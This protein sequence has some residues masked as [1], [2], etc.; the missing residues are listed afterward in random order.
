MP[1]PYLHFAQF[2]L[3]PKGFRR[4]VIDPLRQATDYTSLYDSETTT[5]YV[6]I[7]STELTPPT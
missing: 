3:S 6:H 1:S 2:S 5:L 7:P 4:E